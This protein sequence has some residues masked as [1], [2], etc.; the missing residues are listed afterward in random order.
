[1]KKVQE[2]KHFRLIT[3][4]EKSELMIYARKCY[5]SHRI[6]LEITIEINKYPRKDSINSHK[7]SVDMQVIECVPTKKV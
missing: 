1:M 4:T 2:K 5:K 6:E 7:T 3:I